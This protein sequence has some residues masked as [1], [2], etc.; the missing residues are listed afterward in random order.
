MGVGDWGLGVGGWGS[1]VGGCGL[2]VGGWGWGVG[3]WVFGCLGLGVWGFGV[4]AEV[5]DQGLGVWCL[6][7]A[8]NVLDRHV[9]EPKGLERSLQTRE[10][11]ELSSARCVPER[12]TV[13]RLL[14]GCHLLPARPAEPAPPPRGQSLV[15]VKQETGTG[16]AD[17]RG[18]GRLREA[19]EVGLYVGRS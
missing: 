5:W 7:T 19:A 17:F 9:A 18:R 1:G 12:A 2:G 11:D 16:L 4:C 10:V 15:H 14:L 8:L 3:V 13:A 6:G